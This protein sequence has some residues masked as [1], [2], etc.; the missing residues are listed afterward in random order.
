[1]RDFESRDGRHVVRIL[2]KGRKERTL[3]MWPE[4]ARELS[5]FTRERGLCDGDHIFAG[6][7]VEHMSRSGARSRID[8]VARRA[9]EAHPQLAGKRISA[10]VFRH[11]CAMSM[12]DSGVDLST[13]AI[14]LGH[15]NV[16]T[17]HKYMVA[18]M[19]R[20][21]AALSKVHPGEASEDARARYAP[22][23]DILDFL[24]S[25]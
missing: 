21:A 2:G 23:E 15:E 3:P 6:R 20:K 25:L 13:I 4:V 5:A 22:R 18:D 7:N 12:L 14:W 11:S 9:T 16:Q 19:A 24:M 10:H 8:A 1:V 17:T